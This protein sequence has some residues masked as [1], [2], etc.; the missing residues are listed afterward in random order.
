LN[1]STASKLPPVKRAGLEPFSAFF[2]GLLIE[3]GVIIWLNTAKFIGLGDGILA[4]II[5]AAAVFV[6][7][8]IFFCVARD[9]FNK[10]KMDPEYTVGWAVAA[11]WLHGIIA[12][13]AGVAWLI[14]FVIILIRVIGG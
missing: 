6:Y 2:V 14:I 5:N 9:E 1:I 3:I 12:A 13:L 4:F 10:H 8:A 11:M 7:P